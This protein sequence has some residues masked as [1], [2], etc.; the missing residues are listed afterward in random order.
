[1]FSGKDEVEKSFDWPDVIP[2]DRGMID[3]FPI[4]A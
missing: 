2:M 3:S 4:K 1:M